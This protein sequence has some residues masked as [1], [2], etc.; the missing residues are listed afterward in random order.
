MKKLFALFTCAAMAATLATP[1]LAAATPSL[2]AAAPSLA[3]ATALGSSPATGKGEGDYTIGVGGVFV[4]GTPSGDVISADIAWEAMNFTYTEGSVGTWNPDT[5]TYTGGTEGSWSTNKPA[6]TVTNHSNTALEATFAFAAADGVTTTG[7]FYTKDPSNVYTAI[8]AAAD[9]K[10]ALATA[11]GTTRE[12]APAG[13]LCFGV[14]GAGISEN[15]S[16]GT[17]TVKIAKDTKI[18]TG[19]EL[20]AALTALATTGG[21]ITLGAD[22]GVPYDGASGS[23]FMIMAAEGQDIVLDL[24]GHTLTGAIGTEVGSGTSITIKNGKITYTYT[25]EH[26]DESAIITHVGPGTLNL[27]GLTVDTPSN[28]ALLVLGS[29]SVRNCSFTGGITVEEGMTA[30]IVL[31]GGNL[32]L[33]GTVSAKGFIQ[34]SNTWILELKNGCQYAFNNA[35]EATTATADVIYDKFSVDRPDWLIMF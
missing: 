1:S 17:I 2:A 27:E 28:A 32:T 22:I 21:T 16:L 29:V 25:G 11:V 24:N 23:A 7:S 35:T 18:Y 34:A 4:P 8:T 5:H 19:E 3:A 6:I 9:Q 26:A 30:T 33:S 31:V 20:V 13:S 14:S 15:K 10:L 12:N